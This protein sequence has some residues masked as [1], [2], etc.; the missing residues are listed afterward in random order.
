MGRPR[1]LNKYELVGDVFYFYP[2]N[3]IIPFIIDVSC[4]DLITH[5]TWYINHYGYVYS[6]VNGKRIFLHRL[7]CN[8]IDKDWRLI[9]VDHIN[10][11]K[12]DN[13]LSNLLQT[14]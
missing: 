1:L 8:V 4:F 10:N 3:S 14:G 12:L 9:Q 6:H 2:T 7:L 11:N 13:T 5:H